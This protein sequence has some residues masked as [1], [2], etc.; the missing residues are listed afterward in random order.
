[1]LSCVL[2]SSSA[3]KYDIFHLWKYSYKYILQKTHVFSR[4][5]MKGYCFHSLSIREH[6]ILFSSVTRWSEAV[7]TKTLNRATMTQHLFVDTSQTKD[8]SPMQSINITI[9]SYIIVGVGYTYVPWQ[10]WTASLALNPNTCL[11]LTIVKL[12]FCLRDNNR[13]IYNLGELWHLKSPISHFRWNEDD[14]LI[15]AIKR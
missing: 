7:Y 8:I 9:Y 10:C 15:N 5:S 11:T 4:F 2:C 12:V 14:P 3:L 6:F 13:G 1:M